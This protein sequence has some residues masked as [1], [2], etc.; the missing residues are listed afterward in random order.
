MVRETEKGFMAAVLQLAKIHGWRTYH[1]FDS[2]RSTAGFPDLTL[3]RG[4]RCIMAELKSATGKVTKDQAAW[5]AALGAVQGVE[6]ALWRPKD[7]SIIATTL[8]REKPL[9][10]DNRGAFRFLRGNDRKAATQ[11]DTSK[12]EQILPHRTPRS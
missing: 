11:G 6:V 7:W 1:T 4:P 10:N 3:V 8:K 5:L 12:C 2:R 9:G